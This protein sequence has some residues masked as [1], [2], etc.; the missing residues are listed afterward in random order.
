VRDLACWASAGRVRTMKVFQYQ[1][2][3]MAFVRAVEAEA[4]RLSGRAHAD[5]H[6]PGHARVPPRRLEWSRGRKPFAGRVVFCLV[7]T[8]DQGHVSTQACLRLVCMSIH[9]LFEQV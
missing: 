7:L 6:T 9:V 8:C 4:L 3:G 1:A 5:D 2:V